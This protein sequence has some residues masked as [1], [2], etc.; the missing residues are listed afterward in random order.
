VFMPYIGGVPAY[1]RKCQ[2]V[3]AGGYEGFTVSR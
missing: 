1:V 3:A 2:E